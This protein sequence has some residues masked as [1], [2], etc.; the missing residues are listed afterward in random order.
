MLDTLVER[1]FNDLY[2]EDFPFIKSK[3]NNI[4]I[5]GDNYSYP[6][7][8]IY[9]YKDKKEKKHYKIYATAVGITKD[10]IKIVIKDNNILMIEFDKFSLKDDNE[11]EI[12]KEIPTSKNIR[13]IKFNMIIDKDN[14]NVKLEN[15]LLIID[16]VEKEDDNVKI[17]KID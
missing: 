11:E 17:I 7:I 3:Q 12:L 6:K 14:I 4:L 9:S 1:I 2:F 13:L 10:K 16:I 8:N 15:G 5:S